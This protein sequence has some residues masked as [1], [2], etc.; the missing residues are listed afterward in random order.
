MAIITISREIGSDGEAVARGV[1]AKM[2]YR[3]AAK[4]T[5]ENV[6]YQYG[7]VGFDGIYQSAPSLWARSDIANQELISMLNKA[8][9]GI[10]RLDNVVILGRGGYAALSS[11]A[12]VLNV[13]IQAPFST[14]VKCILDREGFEK[15]A[16][17]E[18]HV[19]E[20]DKARATFVQGFYNAEFYDTRQFHLVLDMSVI[21]VNTAI[22]WIAGGAQLLA[23]RSLVDSLT[24]QDIVV[25]QVLADAINQVLMS[26]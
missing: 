11:Y 16:K 9:L 23:N 19:A 6:L 1:A 15:I 14:R 7:F 22:E 4:N 24:T 10:A 2:G 13:R 8:I 17:A 12:D 3:F 20:N 26:G 25:D 5:F 18:K 21:P